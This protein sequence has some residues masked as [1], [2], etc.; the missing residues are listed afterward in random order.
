MASEKGRGRAFLRP[1]FSAL[2]NILLLLVVYAICRGVFLLENHALFPGLGG[3][4]L[5]VMFL[6]GIR[7]DLTAILYLSLPYLI[8]AM[9]PLRIREA[10]AWRVVMKWL[11]VLPNFAGVV[12]TL[13]DVVYFPFTGKR[14]TWSIFQEF[15]AEENLVGIFIHEAIAHWYLVLLGV[16]ILLALIFLYREPRP[17][18]RPYSWKDYLIHILILL[19]SLVPIVSGMRG[20]L[21]V[22]RPISLQDA[23]DYC[24]SPTETGIVLNTAFSMLRTIGNSS[25]PEPQWLDPEEAREMF[26]PVKLPA[27][28]AEFRP[29][30]VVVFI[31]E[32][33]SASY[34]Q[35]LT[36]WQGKEYE[37]YMPFLDSLMQEGLVF[38]HSFAHDRQSIC[39]LTAIAAG[40]P[41]IVKPY[42]LSPYA[43][44][45]LNGF[46]TDLVEQKGYSSVFYHGCPRASLGITGVAGTLGFRGHY[47]MEDF[48]DDSQFDGLWGIWDEPFLQ[49]FERGIEDLQEPFVASVFTASSHHPF[50][51]P[52]G[53]EDRFPEGRIP[54]H[55]C[56]KY[57]DNSI[58][59]FFEKARG[60]DWFDNTL[61]V[62]TG[63]HCN[64]ADQPEYEFSMLGRYLIPIVF[65]TPDGSLKGMREGVAMQADIQSTVMSYL[66]YDKPFVS[67]GCDLLTTPDEDT[68]AFY[69]AL[70]TYYYCRDGYVLSF[71]LSSSLGL[72]T[73]DDLSLS[74]NLLDREPER[75]D[76]LER[77][78]HAYVQQLFSR[79]IH[80]EM[81]LE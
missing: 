26:D 68:F 50:R 80:N 15:G 1:A 45:A 37:G 31:L 11:Y 3:A 78:S 27:E 47:N 61:F 57:A 81:V 23:N 6:G 42:I 75:R 30:N 7:F 43:N 58:R 36:G 2:C 29:K 60:E 12:A 41:T 28:D 55:K 8:M 73:L 52:P 63:D 22:W 65:W 44:N 39:A 72:Y 9:L 51:L 24:S 17:S 66:G 25:F 46:V 74:D 67:F 18:G 10:K 19:A 21:T 35:F 49:A 32:S 77:Q 20:G 14:S 16:A 48:N 64:D 40:L 34:S 4:R 59:L 38:R 54:M 5:R 53:Y 13:C 71:N 70:G 69:D 33:F 76:L 79:I 56:V 62:F